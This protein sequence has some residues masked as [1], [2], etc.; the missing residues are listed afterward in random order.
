LLRAL[1]RQ[2]LDKFHRREREN[3]RDA[4][5][6]EVGWASIEV[7]VNELVEYEIAC[8]ARSEAPAEMHHEFLFNLLLAPKSSADAAHRLEIALIG[9]IDRL[10]IYR[11]GGRIRRLKLSDY[12]TSRR[13]SDYAEL[14]SPSHFAYED[15]QM[16]VYA[17]GAAEHFRSEM[18][19]EAAVE[20]SYIALRDRDKESEPQSVPLAVLGSPLESAGD[21]TVA[22]RIVNLV[23]DAVAGRFDVDPLQCSQYCPYRRV[24]RYR[25]PGF[26]P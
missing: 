13:L 24:C 5:F 14:L 22:A 16:P 19:A 4:T 7:M 21:R 8:R 17:L 11:D 9:R 23:A 1:T 3:A 26:Q 6:F 25:K 18:P 2:V 20:V 15:L 10:E 12:K